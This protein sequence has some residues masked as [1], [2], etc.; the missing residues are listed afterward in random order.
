MSVVAAFRNTLLLG[1]TFVCATAAA[2]DPTPIDHIVVTATRSQRPGSDNP[3]AVSELG[4]DAIVDGR[5]TV[6]L[7]ESLNRVPGVLVQNSGNY[8]QDFRI[9]V[10]GFGTR[11]AFGVREVKVLVDG[12]PATLPDGQTQL[13]A[14]DPGA[15]GRIEVLRRSAGALYGNASGGVIQLF[16]RDGPDTPWAEVRSLAGRFGL[17][18]HQLQQGGRSGA[19]KWLAHVSRF[20]TDGHRDH[21]AARSTLGR[22]RLQR[23]IG[24]RT[25]VTLHVDAVDAPLAEDPGG[26]TR[27][28]ADADRGAARDRNVLLDAG[29]S[30][31]QVRAAVALSHTDHFGRL[32]AYAYALHRDFSSLLPVPPEIGA[33]AVAF[34]RVSPGAGIQYELAFAAWATRHRL[35]VGVDV[36]HQDD[37]RSRFTNEMGMAAMPV[38]RQRERVT[39]VG[40]YLQHTVQLLDDFEV[41][42]GAR[43]DAIRFD[44]DVDF[45]ASGAPGG[46]ARTLDAFSPAAGWL[47]R[48]RPWASLFASVATAFQTPTTTEL[49]AA[50]RGGFDP[51]L[52]PQESTTVELGTRID[53]A[54]FGAGLTAFWIRVDDEIIRFEAPGGRD[55]FRNAGRS[56]RLGVEADWRWEIGAGLAWSGAVTWIDATYREY[57]TD[58]GDFAGNDEPGIASWQVFQELRWDHPAGAFVATDLFA[59]DR[60][61]ADDANAATS[62]GY[63]LLGARAGWEIGR[64]AWSLRPFVAVTNLLDQRY[65]GTLRI[66]A[67]GGRYFEPG[68]GRAFFAG[69]GVSA[70]L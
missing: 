1:A 55:A 21:S 2:A 27:S 4:R 26:L 45:D 3:A 70:I 13:D 14:I 8:A 59:L 63:E 53:R 39:S 6:G 51:D 20:T 56:R 17:Q 31:R 61:F 38:L 66:N 35:Q 30:V 36:Q 33:G 48:V 40:P 15:V 44:V 65:D 57:A 67:L 11:A 43:Y 22:L 54:R 50:D 28:E 24:Q 23:E 34:D 52:E 37:D 9:Q 42:A 10:R 32:D 16:T 46:G 58:A 62:P 18:K 5:A 29:E 25:R 69:V 64:G 41:F 60:V 68:P 7:D 19:W 47:W 12:I 49:G